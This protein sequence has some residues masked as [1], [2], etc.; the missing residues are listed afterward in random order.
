LLGL[1][2]EVVFLQIVILSAAKNPRISSL[3][4][5]SRC[6][7]YALACFT[8]LLVYVAARS[9][10]PLHVVILNAVKD[11][12]ICRCSFCR[13]LFYVILNAVK[14]PCIRRCSLYALACFTPLLV[15]TSSLVLRSPFH[16]AIL[17][18]VKD[19]RIRR[20]LF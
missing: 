12:C 10:I 7:F 3:L 17:N 15:L 14:G 8:L 13:Y 19:P 20:C 18:A 1:F 5:L 11:P 2:V 6:S 16:V 4:V 9:A